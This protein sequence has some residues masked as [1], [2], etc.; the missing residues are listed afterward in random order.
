MKAIYTLALLAAGAVLNIS[1]PLRASEAAGPIELSFNKSD[2]YPSRLRYDAV[3]IEEKPR[4]QVNEQTSSRSQDEVATRL[5][6]Q[7]KPEPG[8]KPVATYTSKIELSPAKANNAVQS[9]EHP[10]MEYSGI[11]VQLIRDNPLQ[12]VSPFAPARYGDG[13]PN[14]VRNVITGRAEGV[15]VLTIRF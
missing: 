5:P 2:A 11:L 8:A 1:T 15:R 6:P 4:A 10:G 12:L 3:E 7:V 13:E 14:T 9:Q